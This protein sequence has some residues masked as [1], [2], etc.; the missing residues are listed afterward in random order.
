MLYNNSIVIDNV[1]DKKE[2]KWYNIASIQAIYF[3]ISDRKLIT[4]LS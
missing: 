3:I 4:L 1:N 2:I